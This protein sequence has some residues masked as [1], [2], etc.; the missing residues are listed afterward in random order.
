MA[1]PNDILY[2]ILIALRFISLLVNITF[3]FRYREKRFLYMIFGWFIWGISPIFYLVVFINESFSLFLFGLLAFIGTYYVISGFF[4][5]FITVRWK[6]VNYGIL[7]FVLPFIIISIIFPE[8]SSFPLPVVFQFL[9]L[10]IIAFIGIIKYKKN[11]PKH[12]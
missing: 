11:R 10:A 2:V 7:G 3:Y 12:K 6:W 9:I 1:Q 5:E 4:D 8:L